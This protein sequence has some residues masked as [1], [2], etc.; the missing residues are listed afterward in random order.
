ML[1]GEKPLFIGPKDQQSLK[2][3]REM[4]KAILE[5]EAKKAKARM[6]LQSENTVHDDHAFLCKPFTSSLISDLTT[7]IPIHNISQM[8]RI[9]K[10]SPKFI[11]NVKSS[12]L[13]KAVA[14]SNKVSAPFPKMS[15]M[16]WDSGEYC[17][18]FA[19]ST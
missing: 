14:D 16:Q 6:I 10:A 19:K 12:A 17:I 9:P 4:A 13:A 8:D 3:K 15:F 18:Y 7:P 1:A 5:L 11:S 2:D